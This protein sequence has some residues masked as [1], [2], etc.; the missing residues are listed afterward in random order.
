MLSKSP[1][2]LIRLLLLLMNI[3]SSLQFP[4][5]I[6]AVNLKTTSINRIIFLFQKKHLI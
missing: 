1:K 5:R 2:L 4:P 3:M 6:S